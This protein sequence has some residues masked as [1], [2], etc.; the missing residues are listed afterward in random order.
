LCSIL[1]RLKPMHA[2]RW[3]HRDGFLMAPSDA[4]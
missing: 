2:E 4:V 3:R 1:V